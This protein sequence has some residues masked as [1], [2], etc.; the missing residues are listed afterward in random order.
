MR[1]LQVSTLCAA[2]ALLLLLHA[3]GWCAPV[4]MCGAHAVLHEDAGQEGAGAA[5]SK[6]AAR[7]ARRP[8]PV[9]IPREPQQQVLLCLLGILSPKGTPSR[10]A[11]LSGKHR[12]TPSSAL[13]CAA[14][15]CSHAGGTEERRAACGQAGGMVGGWG[16]GLLGCGLP[17]A[18]LC[19]TPPKRPLPRR[20]SFDVCGK[21]RGTLR[22]WKINKVGCRVA[23]TSPCCLPA[24]PPRRSNWVE[25]GVRGG[26]RTT[27]SPRGSSSQGCHCG[28]R[29][30]QASLLQ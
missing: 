3:L 19:D 30:L 5:V 21:L 13:R 16:C 24:K 22:P 12:R 28:M 17:D 20:T 8:P 14:A 29:V 10:Q 18:A 27:C 4:G 9:F 7:R 26:A 6:A 1:M 11:R 25:G 23:R 2:G 15:G